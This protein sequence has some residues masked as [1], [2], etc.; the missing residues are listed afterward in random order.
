MT[1]AS[2]RER[3]FSMN[4]AERFEAS[5]K[6]GAET[7]G[8]TPLKF[9]SLAE[10]NAALA[11]GW[12]VLQEVVDRPRVLAAANPRILSY[13]AWN[14]LVMF[15]GLSPGMQSVRT[16][17]EHEHVVGFPKLYARWKGAKGNPWFPKAIQDIAAEALHQRAEND[18][19]LR[20]LKER[21]ARAFEQAAASCA[22][23]MNL[24]PLPTRL[25][26]IAPIEWSNAHNDLMQHVAAFQPRIVV[27]VKPD[28]TRELQRVVPDFEPRLPK[29]D[30]PEAQLIEIGG[31]AIPLITMPI[32]PNA[33]GKG[34]R[35]FA[36][37]RPKVIARIADCLN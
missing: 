5:A 10:R 8:E 6:L 36:D 32:H 9:N 16:P 28:V 3:T 34:F 19:Q 26:D 30:D 7:Y 2:A 27:A 24:S 13:G 18:S 25:G 37:S 33:T 14:P 20:D 35:R 21:D 29:D 4:I 12:G 23:V 1:L 17:R 11:R 22:L 31:G 15:L